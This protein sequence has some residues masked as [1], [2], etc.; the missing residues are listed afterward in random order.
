M[1]ILSG[2]LDSLEPQNSS[3][4]GAKQ[5]GL[6]S[7]SLIPADLA[8]WPGVAEYIYTT[9]VKLLVSGTHTF[10][11]LEIMFCIFSSKLPTFDSLV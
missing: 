9:G 4:I 6:N 2:G 10:L 1:A 11:N 5:T 3:Q 8:N 7:Q